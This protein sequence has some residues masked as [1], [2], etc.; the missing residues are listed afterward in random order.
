M[1]NAG[2]LRYDDEF[3]KHKVLDAMGDMY[4]LGTPLLASYRA[5]K[6]GHAL[7]NKLIRALMQNTEAWEIVTF[8]DASKA[9]AGFAQLARAW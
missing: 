7:N 6:S 4:M 3:V 8:D 1:L 2:G 5:M 9:P